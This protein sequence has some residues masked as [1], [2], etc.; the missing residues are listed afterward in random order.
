MPPKASSNIFY[1]TVNT[2][3]DP[4]NHLMTRYERAYKWL[5]EN[6]A[7]DVYPTIPST[8]G[9]HLVFKV[10]IQLGRMVNQVRSYARFE[11]MKLLYSCLSP[12]AGDPEFVGLEP[13]RHPTFNRATRLPNAIGYV[14]PPQLTHAEAQRKRDEEEYHFVNESDAREAEKDKGNASSAEGADEDNDKE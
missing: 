14:P 3:P 4:I 7:Y 12:R 10:S 1:V 6:T 9:F 13:F 2:G 5:S 8:D 11:T